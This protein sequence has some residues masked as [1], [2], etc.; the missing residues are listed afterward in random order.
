M[1]EVVRRYQD[2]HSEME[3]AAMLGVGRKALWVRRR[4]WGLYRNGDPRREGTGRGGLKRS[5]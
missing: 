2:T 3:L 4:R 5:A 1:K